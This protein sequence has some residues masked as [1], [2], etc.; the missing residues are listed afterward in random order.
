MRRAEEVPPSS[1]LSTWPHAAGVGLE[2]DD[3]DFGAGGH[4]YATHLLHAFAARCPPPLADWAITSFT[5]PGDVVLDPMM[6][7]G[8]TLVE[9][10]LLGRSAWG[11]DI[12]P[13]ARLMAK[14]KATPVDVGALDAAVKQV[15]ERVDAGDLDADWRPQLD[16]VDYWFREDVAADLARL[17]QAIREVDAHPDVVDLLWV[18]FSSLIVGRTSV[19]N[20][21]DLVHSRHHYR[22]WDEDPQVLKRFRR[23]VARA[24]RLMSEYVDRLAKG[25]AAEPEVRIVGT[26]ARNLSLPGG[27]VDLVFTSPP[28]CSAL[29]YTRAH[30]FG[31]AWLADVLDVTTDDYR[32]LGRE[33]VGTERAAL[34]HATPAQPLPPPFGNGAIDEIILAL[35]DDPKRA[36]IVYRY[37]ADMVKVLAESARVTKADGHVVLVVCP[38][39]IRKVGVPTHRILADLATAEPAFGSRLKLVALRERTIHDRRR[40]MPYL[41]SAFG[42][43]MRTE[44]VIVLRSCDPE[45]LPA[46]PAAD[47]QT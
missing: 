3:L 27:S 26:D 23:Q 24:R 44:Y 30:T 33:Y 39:N 7:S 13:L 42:Q 32:L 25:S 34:R 35:K 31:I 28:Y 11:A 47:A 10:C 16:R 38:S 17:R 15:G 43:R 37:F 20:A 6:G 41:E 2:A 18:V 21:R 40:V 8:T 5:K 45:Q 19:A 4:L 14:V 9:A 12:D 46:G 36:W 29:D 22:A 1:R